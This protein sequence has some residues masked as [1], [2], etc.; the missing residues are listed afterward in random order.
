[1]TIKSS[2][3]IILILFNEFQNFFYVNNI[4]FKIKFMSSLK[5]KIISIL[6][7]QTQH[8][9]FKWLK[10]QS[11]KILHR[12]IKKKKTCTKTV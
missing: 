3:Q 10:E 6:Y 11:E 5:F 12:I 8:Y 1:M 4:N 7:L 2:I 9:W